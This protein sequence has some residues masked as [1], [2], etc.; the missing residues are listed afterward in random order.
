MCIDIKYLHCALFTLDL[1]PFNWWS[2][3]PVASVRKYNPLSSQWARRKTWIWH[4]SFNG[5][6][7]KKFIHTESGDRRKFNTGLLNCIRFSSSYVSR[8]HKQMVASWLPDTKTWLVEL[9]A[10]FTTGPRWWS[11]FITFFPIV[12]SNKSRRNSWRQP[13]NRWKEKRRKLKKWKRI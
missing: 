10:T 9:M 1:C 7:S 13:E 12:A 8:D 6:L 4:M 5:R 2:S 11:I 3:V